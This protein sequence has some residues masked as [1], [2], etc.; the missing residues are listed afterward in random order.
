[1]RTAL[2]AVDVQ[3]NYLSDGSTIIHPLTLVARDVNLVIVCRYADGGLVHP[4]IRKLANFTTTRG[5]EDVDY[6]AFD[7]GTLRP[8]HSLEELLRTN[9]VEGVIVGG[10]GESVVFTAC[11]ANAIGLESVVPLNCTERLPDSASE[12]FERSGVQLVDHWRV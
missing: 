12:T 5:Q 10:I 1:M 3:K 11:D 2:L 6:S 9:E 4:Q 7:G 8:A